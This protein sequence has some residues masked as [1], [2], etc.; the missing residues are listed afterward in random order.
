MAQLKPEQ[1][2]RLNELIHK[3]ENVELI[4]SVQIN[5][6]EKN[7]AAFV[8]SLQS[9]IAHLGMMMMRITFGQNDK[10]GSCVSSLNF[11]C[12]TVL[13]DKELLNRWKKS[14]INQ[15]ANKVKHT[16]EEITA[17]I[18]TCVG[19]Y[20][21]MVGSIMDKYGL[22]MLSAMKINGNPVININAPKPQPKQP[23][24]N[25][26]VEKKENKKQKKYTPTFV[27]KSY[28]NDRKQFVKEGACSLSATISHKNGIIEKGLF[29]KKKYMTAN[30]YI[31]PNGGKEQYP[32]AE[33]YGN[34]Y[35]RDDKTKKI[36]LE[37]GNNYIEVEY[38]QNECTCIDLEVCA[39]FKVGLL[40]R[41]AVK[42]SLYLHF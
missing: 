33:L 1:K 8:V 41:K 22:Q 13:N 36:N 25:K 16:L 26:P 38:I 20:D 3:K 4:K 29:N 24:E 14:K 17:L 12:L 6:K 5:A 7:E 11:L 18:N 10:Q 23:Q 40:K 32:L 2:T 19:L 27:K 31:Q 9:L 15:N 21:L 42:T 37:K 35:I 34:V 39:V 30:V 28:D